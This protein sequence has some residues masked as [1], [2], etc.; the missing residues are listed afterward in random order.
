[1]TAPTLVH[2][3]YSKRLRQ[4][5]ILASSGPIEQQRH[6]QRPCK[7]LGPFRGSSARLAAPSGNRAFACIASDHQDEHRT[8]ERSWRFSVVRRQ[9]RY[10]L[11]QPPFRINSLSN[12]A[13]LRSVHTNLAVFLLQCALP[14]L[15]DHPQSQKPETK[16]GEPLTWIQSAL[17]APQDFKS[18]EDGVGDEALPSRSL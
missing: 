18:V 14:C 6:R 12:I 1:M 8:N 5:S 17:D 16:M 10:N 2:I 4:G 9:G 3:E 13:S 7:P 11:N 15:C